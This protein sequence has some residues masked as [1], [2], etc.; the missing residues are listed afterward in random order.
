MEV[1]EENPPPRLS[2]TLNHVF[3][4]ATGLDFYGFVADDCLPEPEGWWETLAASAG[5]WGVAYGDDGY[6]GEA[7]CTHP[8]LGGDL[9]RHFGFWSLPVVEHN[10]FDT[11]WH[12]VGEYVG[13]LHYHPEVKFKHQHPLTGKG[14]MD[15]TYIRG[16]ETFVSDKENFLRAIAL[17]AIVER[18][19]EAK[20]CIESLRIE[21]VGGSRGRGLS[22]QMDSASKSARRRKR[23]R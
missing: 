15:A 23:V 11:F 2:A 14:E 5:A 20:T 13:T 1:I 9:V 12:K 16:Q 8:C 3:Q 19:Q 18:V 7:L 21:T 17:P 6:N 10:F 22:A 4:V